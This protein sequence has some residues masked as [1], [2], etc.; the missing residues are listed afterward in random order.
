M[1]PVSPKNVHSIELV[2]EIGQRSVKRPAP[3]GVEYDAIRESPC[4]IFNGIEDRYGEIMFNGKRYAAHV[5]MYE[6]AVQEVLPDGLIVR[7]KCD[8]PAC[9]NPAHLESGTHHDNY[10]DTQ[11]RRRNPAFG[12][13]NG[14]KLYPERVPRGIRSYGEEVTWEK[15]GDI[16]EC[17]TT[18]KSASR[19]DFISI[20]AHFAT[21]PDLVEAIFNGD[22]FVNAAP[23]GRPIVFPSLTR[24]TLT[25]PFP[26]LRRNQLSESQ[27]ADIRWDYFIVRNA[28]RREL[29]RNLRERYGISTA[30]LD[31]I[32][33]RKTFKNVAPEIPLLTEQG[34]GVAILSDHEV[35]CI[36]ATWDAYP[37]HQEKGLAAALARIFPVSHQSIQRIADRQQ[38]ESVP[39]DSSKALKIEEIPFKCLHKS[40]EEHP[41][42]KLTESQVR[43]IRRLNAEEK[44]RFRDIAERF[45]VSDTLIRLI[46]KRQIWKGVD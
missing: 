14:T 31:N 32:L 38:R 9:V 12:N 23:S 39:D 3:S 44:L 24:E 46:V 26:E 33:G 34:S 45:G 40:G 21:T 13:R 16:K 10:L 19:P 7:H 28:N 17:L 20:A 2:L 41:M 42:R 37:T 27:V 29:K 43:E 8:R 4:L 1:H 36:R 35:Q 15:A 5:V 6:T 30:T 18:L 11:K 25:V 22:D